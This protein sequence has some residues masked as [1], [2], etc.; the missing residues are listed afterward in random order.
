M[1]SWFHNYIKVYGKEEELKKFKKDVALNDDVVF[2]F[3][4]FLARHED[5]L[6]WA[7]EGYQG[8]YIL[9]SKNRRAKLDCWDAELVE[10]RDQ[11]SYKFITAHDML[12]PTYD[13][14]IETYKKLR[15][16]IHISEAKNY[17]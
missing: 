6:C 17:R 7:G 15:F 10:G 4:E 13:K 3:E 8:L 5:T 12:E 16:E 9:G 11:L 14:M 1:R 2:S